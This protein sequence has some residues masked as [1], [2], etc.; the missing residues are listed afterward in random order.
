MTFVIS[1][2]LLLGLL[3]LPACLTP[4]GRAIATVGNLWM[5][6]KMQLYCDNR[7]PGERAIVARVINDKL[8]FDGQV[9]IV[10][11]GEMLAPEGA[12]SDN[13]Q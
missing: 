3:T 5:S 6:K 13:V 11:E 2:M 7:T 1:S 4:Q 10:C 8:Y 9:R 12:S